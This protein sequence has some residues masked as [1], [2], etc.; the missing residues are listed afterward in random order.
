[1]ISERSYQAVLFGPEWPSGIA[2]R[3]N[4]TRDQLEASSAQGPLIAL[5]Y[6]DA[7][8]SLTG[9]EDRYVCFS[10]P[11][12][13]GDVRILVSDR[14]IL[15]ELE[16]IGMTRDVLARLRAAGALA[17]RRRRRRIAALAAVAAVLG[18]AL[19][20][21]WLMF[22]WALA[23]AVSAIPVSW[24]QEVGR[25]TASGILA[26]NRVCSDPRMNAAV[27]EIG[28]RLVV[29]VGAAPYGWK[30]R[31]L[32]AADANAFALP[33]GYIFV[34]RGLVE[35]ASD[36]HE[37]AGVLAHE[38][39][40]VLRRHGIENL[41]REIGVRLIVYSAVGD[42]SAVERLAAANA[43]DLASMS[44]S[45][46]QE[47]E[48][49]ALG[50]RLVRGAGLDPTGL[51]RLMSALAADEGALGGALVP[52]D[53]PGVRGAGRIARGSPPRP[54]PVGDRTALGRLER[55]QGV[56][57]PDR[58]RGS[59]H[60]L[61][62]TRFGPRRSPART[63]RPGAAGRRQRAASLRFRS[64]ASTRATRARSPAR[65]A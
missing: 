12:K 62:S 6:A 50:L 58:N 51:E 18:L 5:S 65:A 31:V 45:R 30:L 16:S 33:G 32:D 2:C 54:G 24:E 43:A 56:V 48:A 27:Q 35:R 11:R 61:I 8:I 46:D 55:R 17:G 7:A 39:Q 15:G 36:G 26:E 19:L 34:N 63:P 23:T 22:R 25:A 1:M 60:N 52:V 20:A 3:V 13:G 28:R 57:R 59:G 21:V 49:D 47:R 64:S 4:A 42:A 38:M 9:A 29:G 53:A 40:H 41:A 10:G 44:F 37:V 14:A